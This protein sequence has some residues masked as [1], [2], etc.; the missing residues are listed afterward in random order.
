MAVAVRIRLAVP[1]ALLHHPGVVAE[2]FE[3]P[4]R[5]AKRAQRLAAIAVAADAIATHR[6]AVLRRQIVYRRMLL[7][8]R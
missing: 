7:G 2:E 3:H 6:D 4:R 5:M 8:R 1:P